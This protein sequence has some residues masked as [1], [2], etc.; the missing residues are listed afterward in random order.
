MSG[1]KIPGDPED[2]NRNRAV[3]GKIPVSFLHGSELLKNAG[4][5]GKHERRMWI[6]SPKFLK[7]NMS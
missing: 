4:L 3:T 7:L 2:K 1:D 5:A 6:S